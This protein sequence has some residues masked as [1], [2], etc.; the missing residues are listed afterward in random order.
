IESL[1][2]NDVVLLVAGLGMARYCHKFR[3][4]G[5]TGSD[6]AICTEQDLIQI[7][8]DFRWEL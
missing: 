1:G 6:L 5:I 8:I 7:G 2:R 3:A 4:F